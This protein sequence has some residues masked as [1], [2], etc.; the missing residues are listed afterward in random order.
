MKFYRSVSLAACLA[1]LAPGLALAATTAQPT[2][3]SPNS[4]QFQAARTAL[5][6]HDVDFDF[7]SSGDAG[8]EGP[9][10]DGDSD[11]VGAAFTYWGFTGQQGQRFDLRYQRAR[12]LGEGTR[13]RLLIDA[14]INIL[15]ADR[16]GVSPGGTALLGTLSVG[17]ELPVKPNW[18]IT[19]RV[20]YGFVA[21]GQFFG[22][23]GEI[24]TGSVTSRFKLPS[25]GRGSLTLGNSII[26]TRTIKLFSENAFRARSENVLWRNGVAYQLPL[27]ARMF[28]R[29][30]SL[31]A[32]YVFTFTTG[33]KSLYEQ[34][35]EAGLSIGVRTREAEQ[36]NRFE[37]LRV[38]VLY[39]RSKHEFARQFG[40]DSLTLT[41]G[42]RF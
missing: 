8:E 41:L 31:R 40:Y 39:T 4:V 16:E 12:R 15:R 38:G 7:E 25:V 42:Y 33:G 27:K 13:A 23:A 3:G 17:V 37:Q 6:L 30:A 26:H 32:S 14:P 29:Q 34:I 36:K 24:A 2:Y 28:G 22:G 10:I 11:T 21:A 19:P 18:L 1:A 9:L 35:H 20:S 5:D